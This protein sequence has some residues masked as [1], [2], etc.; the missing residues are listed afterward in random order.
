M[1]APR[2]TKT[3]ISVGNNVSISFDG[4]DIVIR[5]SLT[6]QRSL[7]KTGKSL[8]VASSEGNAAVA[9]PNG[10]QLVVGLNIYTKNK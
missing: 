9:A 6:G 1:T 4:D 7:S 10:E 5:A 2:T 3:S 8:I